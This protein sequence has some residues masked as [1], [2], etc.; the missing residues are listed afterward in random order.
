[1]S[2]ATAFC[3]SLSSP[4]ILVIWSARRAWSDAGADGLSAV[5]EGLSAGAEGLAVEAAG[6]DERIASL[7]VTDDGSGT[8]WRVAYTKKK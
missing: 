2:L 6:S 8:V 5:A 7:M 4:A 3:R 1:M